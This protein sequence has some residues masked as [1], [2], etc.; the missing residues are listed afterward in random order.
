MRERPQV[1]LHRCA[2]Y[3]PGL[4]AAVAAVLASLGGM[5]AFVRPGQRVLIKPN[6]L[7]DHAPAEA[8]TTHPELVRSLIRQVRDCGAAPCVADS[9]ASAVKLARVWER[10]GFAALCAEERVPLLNLEQAGSQR[11]VVEGYAFHVARPVLEADAL[12]NVPKVK[13]HALTLLTAAVKN[14]Y[15]ALPGYQKTH[16]HK[17]YPRP[18][19][20]GRLLHALCRAVPPTLTVADGIVAMDGEGPAAGRPYPLGLLAASAAAPALDMV[21][22]RV[23]GIDPLAVPYLRPF[24]EADDAA[25]RWERIE[26]LGVT[27]TEAQARGFRL[28]RATLTR[29]IPRPLARALAP[30]IWVRPAVDA[31]RC[32]RCGRC[33]AACPTAA[34]RLAAADA[35]APPELLPARCVGCCCCHEV[36]PVAAIRMTASPLLRLLHREFPQ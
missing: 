21:L 20:F 28:P 14:L 13:T 2:D 9:P 35:P 29:W 4:E 8:V 17:D 3:G 11:V 33:A 26:V 32:I 12:I 18:A 16:F 22:C 34:L 5:T 30:L 31:Q 19:G 24:L 25:G 36:C 15:G 7:S 10:T 23:L 6:L 1:A 27:V